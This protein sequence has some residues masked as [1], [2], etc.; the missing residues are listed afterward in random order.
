[1]NI[2]TAFVVASLVAATGSAVFAQSVFKTITIG[3][4]PSANALVQT[5]N[6]RT[7]GASARAT[8]M[9]KTLTVSQVRMQID[10]VVMS[11][12]DLGLADH[13][14][15]PDIVGSARKM[16][17]DQCPGEVGPQLRLQYTNQPETQTLRIAMEPVMSGIH[18]APT[19][20]MLSGNS[21]LAG[22][23]TNSFDRNDLWVFV[24]RK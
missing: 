1:V 21:L 23:S 5:L 2:R 7:V 3:D 18:P 11:V 16:G 12:G 14:K 10:L 4:Y 22:D 17:L 20:F 19:V 8:S 24:R 13:A 15:Y 6:A 9:L